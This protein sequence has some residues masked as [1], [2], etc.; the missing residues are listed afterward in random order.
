MFLLDSNIFISSYRTFYAP[1]FCYGFWQVLDILYDNHRWCS[2]DMVY[3]ELTRNSESEKS[4]H[5]CKWAESRQSYF[6]TFDANEELGKINDYLDNQAV[7]K[8]FNP[9][10][11]EKFLNGADP[12]IIAYAMKHELTL[13]TQETPEPDFKYEDPNN[14]IKIKIPNV[15]RNFNVRYRMLWDFMKA[16]DDIINLIQ[17]SK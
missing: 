14:K 17:V 11:V 5:V 13:V 3:K 8:K 4:D 9:L 16:N 7:N 1:S 10:Q 6:R 2:L 12:F 15:C